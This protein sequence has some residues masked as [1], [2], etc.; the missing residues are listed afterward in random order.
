M[1]F[2]IDQLLL[3][4]SRRTRLEQALTNVGMTDPLTALIAEAEEDV[5]RWTGGYTL[6]DAAKAGWLRA[7]VL[8]KAYTAAAL[9]VPK[10]LQSALDAAKAEM[11]TISDGKLMAVGSASLLRAGRTPPSSQLFGGNG[12]SGC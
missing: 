4:D 12:G 11:K 2:T 6:T 8:H 7:I 5:A 10:E 9:G 1:A 3:S